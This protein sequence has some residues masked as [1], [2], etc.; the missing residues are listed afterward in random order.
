MYHL[1][2]SVKNFAFFS[3]FQ[4][5]LILLHKQILVKDEQQRGKRNNNGKN[6]TKTMK[7]IKLIKVKFYVVHKP[8]TKR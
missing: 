6:R 3:D 2:L 5:T 1:P 8:E 4:E 7:K